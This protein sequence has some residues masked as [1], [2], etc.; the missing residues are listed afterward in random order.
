MTYAQNRNAKTESLNIAPQR[1]THGI[2]ALLTIVIVGAS[3]LIMA[4]GASFLGL[5][6]LDLGYSS[7]KGEEAFFVADGCMDEVLRNIRLNIGYG[8]GT[9]SISLSVENGSCIIDVTDLGGNTRMVV[10]TGTSGSYNKKIRSVYA[11]SGNV[12]TSTSWEERAD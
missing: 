12:I 5:G 10:V 8:V 1:R 6:E 4:F 7:Q 11:L 2:A 3:V 9:G